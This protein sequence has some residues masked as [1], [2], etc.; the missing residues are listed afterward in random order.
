MRFQR[1]FWVLF[2]L[3]PNSVMA[4]ADPVLLADAQASLESLTA[5]TT[6]VVSSKPVIMTE[7]QAKAAATGGVA[8]AAIPTLESTLQATASQGK[9]CTTAYKAAMIACLEQLSPEIVGFVKDYGVIASAAGAT[10]SSIA[11]Q[12]DGIGSL[13]NKASIALGAFQVACAAAQATCSS[14]CGKLEATALSLEKVA[15]PLSASATVVAQDTALA[16]GLAV[17][18]CQKNKLSIQSAITGGIAALMAMQQAKSCKE[19]T[20]TTNAMDCNDKNNIMYNQKNCMCSRNE[21]PAADCQNILIGNGMGA[22]G[23]E[24][25]IGKADG[26]LE[27]DGSLGDL[28]G[29][30]P[31][32]AMGS[33]GSGGAG[34]PGA[35][36]GGSGSVGASGGGSGGGAQDGSSVGRRLNTNILGGG[37]GGGGGGFGSGPG[38]GETDSSLKAYGPG[39]AKDANRVVASEL[40]K[41]VTN[42][43]GRSNWEKVKSRYTDNLRNLTGR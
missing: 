12:C 39:G 35:P 7:A 38:Y 2:F 5:A 9:I 15:A 3:F 32:G 20:A 27:G 40:T 14:T 30:T 8:S 22:T 42:P 43:A 4:Q 10:V 16:S 21:L 29:T 33:N 19:Q 26:K 34:L 23:P 18:S 11:G 41:Q 24:I 31:M 17:S 1:I 28:Y 13:I 6:K 37:S 36:T 25:A